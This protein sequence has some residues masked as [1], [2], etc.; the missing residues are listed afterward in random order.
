MY[1]LTHGKH[2]PISVKKEIKHVWSRMSSYIYKRAV[3]SS[4]V[5]FPSLTHLSRF[6]HL[7][8]FLFNNEKLEPALFPLNTKENI[9]HKMVITDGYSKSNIFLS[10]CLKKKNNFLTCCCRLNL[11]VGLLVEILYT[12]LFCD[13]LH[14]LWKLAEINI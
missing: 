9:T 12:E 4:V 13:L 14:L 2:P 11:F 8:L 5:F 3:F 1:L 6:M 7:L 10:F